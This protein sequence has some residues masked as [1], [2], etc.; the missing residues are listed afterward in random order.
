MTTSSGNAT[1]LTTTIPGS[2]GNFDLR[3]NIRSGI[4]YISP[5]LLFAGKG[6][7]YD[8]NLSPASTKVTLK[9]MSVS[10]PNFRW[11]EFNPVKTRVG[12]FNGSYSSSATTLTVTSSAELAVN[13]VL[14]N[15]KT[16]ENMLV[17]QVPSSTTIVVQ[18]AFGAYVST[19]TTNPAGLTRD[20]A[21]GSN[22]AS[23]PYIKIGTAMEQGST[24]KDSK[25]NDPTMREGST[26]I[27]RRDVSIDGTTEAQEKTSLTKDTLYKN[28]K[29]QNLL[30]IFTDLEYTAFF[31]K[32]LRSS[33]YGTT[34][35]TTFNGKNITASDGIFNSI[36]TYA[37]ANVISATALSGAGND[38]TM[39]KMDDISFRL[40][41]RPG[42]HV[43]FCGNDVKR[44]IQ[45]LLNT[46]S[47]FQINI[48]AKDKEVDL[49]AKVNNY[50]GSFGNLNFIYHPIFDL[51]ADLK[52]QIL[53]VNTE[54]LHLVHLEGRDLKWKDNAEDPAFDGKSGYFLGE[55]GVI[56]SHASE[57]FLFNEF[58]DLID[59]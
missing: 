49:M 21:V 56:V 48:G 1:P 16:R 31:G 3:L 35:T 26:Q 39:K 24:N 40:S 51:T 50:I 58:T 8:G 14:R 37:S 12:T 55:H 54:G 27:C 23:D 15:D 5:L 7:S 41:Q 34:F 6:G 57:H 10:T 36:Y 22:G 46:A 29:E 13:D 11:I 59:D 28:R 45:D 42:K 53:A 17:I 18:R 20:T 9:S 25:F 19:G 33:N 44:T 30:D 2:L 38:L 52:N 32:M 4:K 43:L 47:V